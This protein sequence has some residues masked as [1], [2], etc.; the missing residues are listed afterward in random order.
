MAGRAAAKR[1]AA[2]ASKSRSSETLISDNR[3]PRLLVAAKPKEIVAS[4]ATVSG[5]A[6]RA[7]PVLHVRSPAE[8]TTL[9]LPERPPVVAEAKPIRHSSKTPNSN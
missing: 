4:D 7:A 3:A 1:A 6:K 9:R 2:S 5:A 8:A